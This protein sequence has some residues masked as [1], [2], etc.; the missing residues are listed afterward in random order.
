M[1]LL[2]LPVLVM[3]EEEEAKWTLLPLSVTQSSMV[4]GDCPDPGLAV[5]ISRAES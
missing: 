3:E 2:I 4:A 1:S 5:E